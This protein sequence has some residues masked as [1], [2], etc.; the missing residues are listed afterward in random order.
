MVLLQAGAGF[1]VE[2]AIGV[3]TWVVLGFLLAL[4]SPA[5]GACAFT[6]LVKQPKTS[7]KNKRR[8]KL[9]SHAARG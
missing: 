9:Y 2:I 6:K 8:L 7:N 3:T 5:L 1:I 4:G